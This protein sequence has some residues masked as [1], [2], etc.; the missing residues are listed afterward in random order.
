MVRPRCAQDEWRRYEEAAGQLVEELAAA[1]AS[2][3]VDA[4]DVPRGGAPL[5]PA[6]QGPPSPPPQ[7]RTLA[8]AL[9][10]ME[11]NLAAAIDP[12]HLTG[13]SLQSYGARMSDL[14]GRLVVAPMATRYLFW[15]KVQSV[16]QL[17]QR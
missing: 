16:Q 1:M 8:R 2:H 14:M 5:S 10:L 4:Q 15:K 7:H 12:G 13:L 6:P 9:D 11:F 3:S 17:R